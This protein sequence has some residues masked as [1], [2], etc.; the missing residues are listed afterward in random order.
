MN[1]LS[2]GLLAVLAL[3]TAAGPLGI[4]M[5]LPGLPALQEEL[6]ATPAMT[7]LTISGFMAGMAV[8]NLLFGAIS[9]S[10]GRRR[11]ILVSSAFFLVASVLCALAPTIQALIVARFIQGLAGGASMV[12]AR[13]T[14]PDLARGRAAAR[15]FSALM[16]ITGFA[17]AIAP[18]LGSVILPAFGWRGVFWTLAAVNATQ[19][20]VA[21]FLIDETLPLTHR[22]DN[23]LRGL[24]PRIARC[25]RHREFVGYLLASGLGFGTLF[26]YI[27]ASPLVLQ[28]Q[29]GA[30]P[31]TYAMIFGSMA[32]LIPLSNAANMR[33]IG[34]FHPRTLLR[35]ALVTDIGVGV[36]LLVVA[37]LG[38]TLEVTVPILAV[39]SLMAGFIMANATSLGVEA[40]REVGA[41]A[42]SG[43]MG[44]FQFVVGG[45]VPPL[46]ALGADHAQTMA[47]SVVT[48]AAIALVAVSALTPRP[49]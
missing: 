23:A 31:T 6:S 40:V 29:L 39:L 43:A 11:P 42:G 19:F 13:A 4:D 44:F 1:K 16:A 24:F 47:I 30:S 7:Q 14:I 9:D 32:L 33:A 37:K 3:L 10:T 17:P 35:A 27:S 2:P 41:G 28:T 8:G 45:V 36:G 15:A 5:Y 20:V 18:A 22:S 49:A 48:C 12:V 46:V 34:R 21:Y 38:P 26:S 25:L